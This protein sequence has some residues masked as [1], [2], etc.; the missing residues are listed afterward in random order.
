[1]ADDHVSSD[2]P[3]LRFDD[4]ATH[5]ALRD[6]AVRTL[7]H[8]IDLVRGWF[9]EHVEERLGAKDLPPAVD[10]RIDEAVLRSWFE[11]WLQRRVKDDP[12]F[13]GAWL[14]ELVETE[15]G[16]AAQALAVRDRV[17]FGDWTRAF[18]LGGR[19]RALTAIGPPTAHL[20]RVG[21][22][23]LPEGVG[24]HAELE[25][26]RPATPRRCRTRSSA[27]ATTGRATSTTG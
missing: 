25:A 18:A 20:D 5:R 7:A 6:A 13:G 1:M 14:A 19:A 16:R 26:A 10:L 22:P 17:A 11:D 8:N 4:P 24:D 9:L 21:N 12:R 3:E 15:A 23:E 2:G 27:R